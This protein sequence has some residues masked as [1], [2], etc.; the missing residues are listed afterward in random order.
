METFIVTRANRGI[1]LELTSQLIHGGQRV[2]ATY[3]S[4]PGDLEALRK[5]SGGRLSS[6][7]LDVNDPQ[8]IRRAA[9]EIASHVDRI[10]VLVNNAGIYLKDDAANKLGA[11]AFDPMVESFRVNAVSPLLVTNALLPLLRKGTNP[12]VVSISSQ[13]GSI[14]GRGD[15]DGI[16]YGVSKAALNMG[17]KLMSNELHSQGITAIVLHPGWVQTDMGGK[18]A[19]LTPEQSAKGIVG[20]IANLSPADAGKFF[21]W[22]GQAMAW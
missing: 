15:S 10:D 5:E 6:V 12:R 8:S 9:D 14:A 19:H 22:R 17:N 11:L 20:V 2:V 16:A 3:R 18:N 21:D 1:G 13:L 7:I 4:T